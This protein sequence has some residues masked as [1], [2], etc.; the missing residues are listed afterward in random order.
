MSLKTRRIAHCWYSPLSNTL[1]L[2]IQTRSHFHFREMFLNGNARP[3]HHRIVVE[4]ENKDTDNKIL[5]NRMHTHTHTSNPECILQHAI[6]MLLMFTCFMLSML[7]TICETM[8]QTKWCSRCPFCLSFF[9]VVV[10][11][12]GAERVSSEHERKARDGRRWRKKAWQCEWNEQSGSD[13]NAYWR[14]ENSVMC[15]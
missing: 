1:Y 11:C 3:C 4:F 12:L 13:Y 7:Y 10:A 5:I 9:F 8:I 15:M 2:F 14:S 6:S